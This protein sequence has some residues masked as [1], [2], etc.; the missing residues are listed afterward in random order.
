MRRE[1]MWRQYFLWPVTGSG[2]GDDDY[3]VDTASKDDR[4]PMD[5]SNRDEH[6]NEDETLNPSENEEDI[7]RGEEERERDGFVRGNYAQL[8]NENEKLRSENKKLMLLLEKRD[9]ESRV[10]V[11]KATH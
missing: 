5:T 2:D 8:Q 3:T 6:P 10:E 9:E 4:D 1:I 7:T 11:N